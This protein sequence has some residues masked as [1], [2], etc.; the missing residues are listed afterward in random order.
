MDVFP[1]RLLCWKTEA[2]LYIFIA[3]HKMPPFPTQHQLFTS[4]LSL[5]VIFHRNPE[6]WV[7][8]AQL[9]P[10]VSALGAE[11]WEVAFV[12]TR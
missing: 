4:L 11:G 8:V 5:P 1:V 3:G 7:L 2:V 6:C 10:E 9:F 12:F